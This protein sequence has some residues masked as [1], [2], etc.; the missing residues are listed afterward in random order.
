MKR[1]GSRG[2]SSW[3]AQRS[4]TGTERMTWSTWLPQPDQVTLPHDRHVTA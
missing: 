4:L 3:P 2:S 1:P